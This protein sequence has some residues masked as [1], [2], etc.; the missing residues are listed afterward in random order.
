MNTPCPER[1]EAFDLHAAGWLTPAEEREL[2]AHPGGTCP[3]CRAEHA[4]AVALAGALTPRLRRG[5]GNS[6]RPPRRFPCPLGRAPL[7]SRLLP[8]LA[9]AAAVALVFALPRSV[10]RRWLPPTTAQTRAPRPP[11]SWP[12]CG[13]PG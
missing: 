9:L 7:P 3:A 12:T 2:L 5:A 1:R 6:A 13:R 4:R 11:P 8:W 10:P